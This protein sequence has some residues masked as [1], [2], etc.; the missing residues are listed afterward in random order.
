MGKLTVTE[1]GCKLKDIH[2][3]FQNKKKAAMIYGSDYINAEG[4]HRSVSITVHNVT[5]N[6]RN[7]ITLSDGVTC[8]STRVQTD[9]GE[10]FELS[11]FTEPKKG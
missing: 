3:P 6:E 2:L 8:E 1:D 11:L 7:I 9:S 5:K 10:W 4:S